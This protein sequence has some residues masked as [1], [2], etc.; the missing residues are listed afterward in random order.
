[1]TYIE[2]SQLTD[3][4][5]EADVHVTHFGA[6]KVS[7]AIPVIKGNFPGTSLDS[8]IWTK[9][10]SG[11]G[12]ITVGEGVGKLKTGT[13]STGSVKLLSKQSGVF[14]AGQVTV[15][16]SGVYPGVGVANNNRLWGLLTSD[17]QD[18]LY[19]K[20][21]GETFYVVAKKAGTET[22]VAST[23]FNREV[24]TPSAANNTFR[25]HYSAGR[26]LF[27]RAASGKI[28][29]LHIMVDPD[30]PLVDELDIGLYYENTNTGNTTDVELRVRGASSSVIG[31]LRRFNEGNAQIVS[32]FGT[33]VA[34]GVVPGYRIITKFGRNED[35]DTGSAPEDIW[36][37][38]GDYTGMDATAGEN[39]SVASANANDV[40]TTR[41]T[42]TATGG[43][44][45]T[46]DD[47]GANFTGDG[48]V[49]NDVLVN[50]T[51]GIHGVITAVTATSV[52]VFSMVD[53]PAGAL[54]NSEGDSYRIV[55]SSGTGAAMIR[56]EQILDANYVEQ[57]PKYAVLNGTSTVTVSGSFIRCSRARVINSGSGNINAGVITINQAVTTANVFAN[58]PTTGQTV[59]SAYTVPAGKKMFLKRV[60]TAIT[61]SSGAAGSAIISLRARRFGESFV[62]VRV[63]DVQAGSGVSFNQEG[64]DIFP[65]GTDIKMR[66]ESVSDNNTFAEGVF[67]FYLV[68]A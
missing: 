47:S 6:L 63:F 54:R 3:S 35:I 50:D 42:G 8:T 37:G 46:L 39:I 59:I 68:N 19:F 30:L 55:G 48:V 21:E 58:V 25:I 15:Y 51:Q 17:E 20:W 67:E 44:G 65:A 26:A 24:W 1:M 52:T 12:T 36:Q 11:T 33:E 4:E 45:T 23:S 14:E 10:I 56:M 9:A 29:T 28:K 53:G 18:G 13:G 38:G 62:A 66:V 49:V 57:T 34:R 32:D 16:Q 43:S 2:K 64:A 22:K 60:R 5:M 61:R 31:D 7:T 27:Q 40:G 41:S